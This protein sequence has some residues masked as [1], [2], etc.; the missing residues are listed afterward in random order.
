MPHSELLFMGVCEVKSFA[1]FSNLLRFGEIL[2]LYKA[3]A[4]VWCLRLSIS[5]TAGKDT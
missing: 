4:E 3:G 5:E 2:L 1:V